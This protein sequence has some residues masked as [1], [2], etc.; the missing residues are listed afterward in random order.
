MIS[1]KLNTTMIQIE[2]LKMLSASMQIDLSVLNESY[3]PMYLGGNKAR[4][5]IPIL[6]DAKRCG[7]NALVSAGSAN[8]NHARVVALAA[9]QLGWHC[10]LIIHDE[11]DY[12][13]ANLQIMKLAGAQ[14]TFCALDDVAVK[15]DEAMDCLKQK[16]LSPYYIWGGGDSREGTLAYYNAVHEYKEEL[17]KWAPDYVFV[18][19]GTGGTQAG[20]HTGFKELFPNTKVIG[21][22]IARN[23][24]RGT[25][26]V[27]EEVNKLSEELN[28][29]LPTIDEIKF[30]DDWVGDGYGKTYPFLLE[31]IKHASKNNG[32]ITDPTYTG[33]ALTAIY[34]M[35]NNGQIEKNSKV[36]FW[37]TGGIFNIF[38]YYKEI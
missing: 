7:S 10:H 20:L 9:A 32:L 22:S 36:L 31:V 24:E 3:F 29:N 2:N 37:H 25:I 15:M 33:K 27:L 12:S 14:L 11:E 8:S 38:E 13:K 16:G 34:D 28:I 21:I 30:L 17:S 23:K 5:I 19:S 18:A 1:Q 26:V 4:K 6:E 35:T